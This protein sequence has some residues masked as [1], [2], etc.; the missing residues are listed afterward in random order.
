MTTS[1]RFA[2]SFKARPVT[3]SLTPREYMSA[4][5]KKL[6]PC[7]S[8]RLTKGRLSLSSSTHGRQRDEPYVIMPRHSLDTLIPVC[9]KRTYCISAAEPSRHCTLHDEDEFAD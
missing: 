4:V 8:A 3:S 5:S 9:P 2:K 6:M 7:S 1:S